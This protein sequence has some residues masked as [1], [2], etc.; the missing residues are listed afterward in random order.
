MSIMPAEHFQIR[1]QLVPVSE[2]LRAVKGSIQR[3]T[4]SW[5]EKNFLEGFQPDVGPYQHTL[6]CSDRTMRNDKVRTLP[7]DQN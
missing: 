2:S 7:D 3:D 4:S 1:K 6:I 5:N